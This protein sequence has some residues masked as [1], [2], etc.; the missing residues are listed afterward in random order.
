MKKKILYSLRTIGAVLIG[1]SLMTSCTDNFLSINTDPDR[2][3]DE[4]L[5]KDMLALG[6]MFPTIMVDVIPTSDVDANEYQRAINLTGDIYSG[7][8]SGIGAW[9]DVN[10]NTYVLNFSDWNNVAFDVAY[11][12]MGSWAQIKQKAVEYDLPSAA[13][14]ADILKVMVL[15]RVSDNYGPIPYS[16]MDG[17]SLGLVYDKQEDVYLG[18]IKDLDTAIEELTEFV[19]ADPTA[20][21]LKKYDLIYKGDY[22]KWIVFANSLKLR[23]AMR[24]VYV[25]PELAKQYAEEAVSNDFGVMTGNEDN[26]MLQ[27]GL[28]ITVYNPLQ[29]CWDRYG[30]TRMGASIESFM[31]GYD[32]PRIGVYFQPS[33]F[34]ATGTDYDGVRNGV[35]P[36]ASSRIAF[37]K[38]SSPN[39]YANTPV[40]WMCAAE[41][42]F[43]RAEGA[44]YGW[45]MGDTAE[46]L[47]AKGVET[48][49]AQR[50]VSAD[51]AKY[52]AD[53]K[54]I[55]ADFVDKASSGSIAHYTD[56]TVAWDT[57]A[58]QEKNLERIITQ[59]YLA[60][61]PDGQ[62]AWTEFRRTGY[63]KL[64]PVVNNRSADISTEKQIRRITFPQSQYSVNE[65]NVKKAILLLNGPDS[66]ATQLWWDCK[67]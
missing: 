8:M 12:I 60:L 9:G 44:L 57:K 19:K 36:S 33:T 11:R 51:Y 58:T 21:P 6:A 7:Y 37:Q 25:R 13:A 26:A 62:E 56:I 29:V 18:F 39:V 5:E 20:R 67:K 34:S 46:N 41:M 2:A 14:L 42:Y 61:F 49:F 47:Y 50:G 16:K 10:N 15:H 40:M 28:G 59:K 52:I 66:G 27:S 64:F 45:N 32:D 30:D 17:T 38:A 63:P 3:T 65:G 23:L 31:K 43:L 35:I 24:M 48:S 1:F 54:S 22:T 55:P 53:D 4:D